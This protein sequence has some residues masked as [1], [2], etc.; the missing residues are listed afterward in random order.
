MRLRTTDGVIVEKEKNIIEKS[1]LLTNL[2]A[3]PPSNEPIE[4]L[5]DSRTLEQ[6]ADFMERDRHVLK[7]GYNPLE[8]H[9]SSETLE[10]F[11]EMDT[12]EV[13]SMCNA[14]NYLEYPYLLEIC[15]KILAIRLNQ[16]TI[17]TKKE[18]LGDARI[19]EKEMESIIQ[20]LDWINENI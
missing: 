4:I 8:I 1:I 2:S 5:V 11:D 14:A 9:F 18:I 19:T 16:D 10:Y 13:L 12:Q 20:D 7:K 6:V 3:L 17:K 15:C